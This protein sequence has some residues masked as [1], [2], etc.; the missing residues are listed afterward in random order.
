MFQQLARWFATQ[1]EVQAAAGGQ[2]PP[3]GEELTRQATEAVWRL[4]PVQLL[5]FAE[6]AWASRQRSAERPD[7]ALPEYLLHGTVP[8]EESGIADLLPG[9][10]E[11]FYH[12]PGVRRP[13]PPVIPNADWYHIAYPCLL[14][15]TGM[16]DIFRKVLLE[17]AT[18]ERLETPSPVTRAW[19]RTT[20]QLFF[21]DPPPGSILSVTSSLRPDTDAV[22][23]NAFFRVLGMKPPPRTRT[24]GPDPDSQ[25]GAANREL[26]RL[27]EDFLGHVKTASDNQLNTSGPNPKDDAAIANGARRLQDMLLTRQRAGNLAQVAFAATFRYEWFSLTL[28]SDNPVMTDL[29]IG[30]KTEG[31]RLLNTGLLVG[32]QAHRHADRFFSLAPRVA[33]LFRQIELGRY[34]NPS[35]VSVLYTEPPGSPNPVRRDLLDI[36]NHWSVATGRDIGAQRTTVTLRTPPTPRPPAPRAPTPRPTAALPAAPRPGSSPPRRI[37]G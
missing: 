10:T 18:D 23:D 22:L 12:P 33:V 30:G 6:E 16:V 28:C 9:L 37:S 21:R 3:T 32:V 27:F 7:L 8:G 4:H 34:N 26:P 5:R 14:S 17:Y 20:E 11:T 2:S 36:I 29:K 13:L 31:M 19:L 24:G 35:A 15:F 25:V 1:I